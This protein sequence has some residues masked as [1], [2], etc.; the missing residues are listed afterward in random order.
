MSLRNSLHNLTKALIQMGPPD[1][2]FVG[3]PSPT[4]TDSPA[5]YFN[6]NDYMSITTRTRCG[7][8]IWVYE[9]SQSSAN[10]FDP[11]APVVPNGLCDQIILSYT[12]ENCAFLV[13]VSRSTLLCPCSALSKPLSPNGPRI[14]DKKPPASVTPSIPDLSFPSLSDLDPFQ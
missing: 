14:C 8:V 2:H 4:T 5:P 13:E 11:E 3:P 9:A 1:P 12:D 7:R 6:L 10:E